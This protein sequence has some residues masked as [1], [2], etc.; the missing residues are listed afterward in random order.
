MERA[1]WVF[2]LALLAVDITLL[3]QRTHH[4]ERFQSLQRESA[5]A[6]L[7]TRYAVEEE[8]ILTGI[9]TVP[10][11]FPRTLTHGTIGDAVQFTMLVSV[12]D[13]TNCIEDE[14]SKLNQLSLKNSSKIS[15][16]QGF[17]VDEGR[18]KMAQ[19]FIEHLSPAPVFPMSVQNTLPYLPGATTPL[20]LVFRS[21]DGKIL[22]A[23]KPIPEDLTKRDAFY[24][25]WSAMLGLN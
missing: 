8:T 10:A 13:C 7:K 9:G 21:R 15:G 3:V 25:R 6:T 17:F 19:T 22:D 14:V 20:V 23:H 12:D 4:E 16:I 11:G 18:R 24:V 5:L 2:V 1:L